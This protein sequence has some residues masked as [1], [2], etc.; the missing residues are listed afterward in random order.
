[1]Q[2]FFAEKMLEI[3]TKRNWI[4]IYIYIYI[5]KILVFVLIENLEVAARIM[6][7]KTAY[8]TCLSFSFLHRKKLDQSKLSHWRQAYTWDLPS[9]LQSHHRLQTIRPTVKSLYFLHHNF[10]NCNFVMI[11]I[12][13]TLEN[14]FYSVFDNDGGERKRREMV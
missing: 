5:Y 1:M 11:S 3:S 14:N 13:A 12:I 7:S 2:C 6:K 10:N 9:V 4:Y 8:C